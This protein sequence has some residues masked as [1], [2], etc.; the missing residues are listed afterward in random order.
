MIRKLGLFF[1]FFGVLFSN[2]QSKPLVVGMELGYPPF[3]MSDKNGNPDGISIELVKALGK[4]LDREIIIKDMAYGGL[5]PSLKTKKID[6]IVSS[7]SI[8]ESRKKSVNFSIPYASSHLAMLVGTNSKIYEPFDLNSKDKILAVKKGTSGH[9]VAKEYFP[10]AKLLVFEKESACM[11]EVAQGKVDAFIY[12]PLTIYKFWEKNQETTIPLFE[13][14]EKESQAWGIA[15]RKN[16]V[17]LGEQIDEFLI[18]FKSSGGFDKLTEKYLK[19]E[20][21][22]FKS[23]NIPFF[24][25]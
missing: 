3:E 15:Y 4:N 10:K 9:T 12:D 23:K 8:T 1:M 16:D 21:E 13:R 5:I 22:F 24:F 2:V 19:K 14:F 17:G 25:E 18:E 7:M 20:K 11:L 6:I